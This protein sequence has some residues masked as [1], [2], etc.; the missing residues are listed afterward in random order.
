MTAHTSEHLST[1][2]HPAPLSRWYLEGLR[3]AALLPVRWQGLQAPPA[4]VALLVTIGLLLS[5]LM[6]RLYI[7]GPATFYWQAIA[8][9]WFGTALIAW[10]SYLMRPQPAVESSPKAAPSAA[11]LLCMMLAQL[12]VLSFV[13]G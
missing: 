11:H 4:T 10:V 1:P 6:E 7:D 2:S 8:S 13:I 12:Q 9:G 5:L 3:S